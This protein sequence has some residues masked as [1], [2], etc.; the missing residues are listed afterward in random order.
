MS[1]IITKSEH[2]IICKTVL[3]D[4]SA[5]STD[6]SFSSREN[7]YISHLDHRSRKISK[8]LILVLRETIHQRYSRWSCGREQDLIW[9]NDPTVVLKVLEIVVIKWVRARI[10]KIDPRGETSALR[11]LSSQRL[12]E[13]RFNSRVGLSVVTTEIV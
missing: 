6:L 7:L 4:P 8:E 5:V 10:I 2:A 13:F 9:F 1:W 3:V 11:A 12:Q